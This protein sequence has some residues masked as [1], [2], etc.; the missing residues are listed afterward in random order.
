MAHTALIGMRI[1]SQGETKAQLFA[2]G[3][4]ID[5][6]QERANRIQK[7]YLDQANGIWRLDA[8]RMAEEIAKGLAD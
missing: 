1:T 6:A 4:R 5:V 8:F 7:L 2:L 3:T